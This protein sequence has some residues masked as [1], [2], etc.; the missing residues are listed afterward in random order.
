MICNPCL[1]TS[2]FVFLHFLFRFSAQKLFVN[3]TIVCSVHE[4]IMI[5][6]HFTSPM[7]L[8]RPCCT[9]Q[10][11]KE[12]CKNVVIENDDDKDDDGICRWYGLKTTRCYVSS[13]KD[14]PIKWPDEAD[15]GWNPWVDNTFCNEPC[16]GDYTDTCGG[17]ENYLELFIYQQ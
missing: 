5:R 4:Q 3:F 9:P 15:D 2:F 8:R 6:S 13:S 1:Y 7:F 11:C 14:A 12:V 17:G 16:P 10:K